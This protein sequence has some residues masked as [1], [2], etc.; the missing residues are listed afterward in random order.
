MVS[1]EVAGPDADG[2]ERERRGDLP[3][4]A[5]AARREHWVRGH[6][7]DHLRDENEGA[8]LARMSAP[9][10]SLRDDQVCPRGDVR[11]GVPG[12]AHQAGRDDPGRVR[13]FL[14]VAGRRTE[15]A[16]QQPDLVRTRDIPLLTGPD[17][18]AHGR[19]IVRAGPGRNTET[20]L[21]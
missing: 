6:R 2:A 18:T 17:V 5:D 13:R 14:N 3:S 9:F 1:F 7:I 16:G 15:R 10:G 11:R 19:A 8:D 4:I 20:P 12:R 21:K